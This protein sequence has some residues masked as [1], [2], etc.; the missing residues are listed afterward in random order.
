[1]DYSNN[2]FIIQ[3]DVLKNNLLVFGRRCEELKKAFIYKGF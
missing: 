2:L 3:V 1:M